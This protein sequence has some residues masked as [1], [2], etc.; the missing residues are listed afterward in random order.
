MNVPAD[1]KCVEDASL[2]IWRPH[3]VLNEALVNEILVFLADQEGR[4][5]RSY[6]RFTDMSALNAVDL[7]FKYVFQVALYRRLSRSGREQVKSAFLITAADMTR[8]V[9]LHALMTDHSPLEVAIFEEY[10]A[11]AKWLDVAPEIL[12]P[13]Q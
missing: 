12:R 3:G 4:R 2:L 6:N 7:S 11:A 13:K 10:E 1:V 8:P 9:K 5:R